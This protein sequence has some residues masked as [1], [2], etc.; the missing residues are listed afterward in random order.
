M[1][2]NRRFLLVKIDLH[3]FYPLFSIYQY[4]ISTPASSDF[5]NLTL[6]YLAVS[7]WLCVKTKLYS[8]CMHEIGTVSNNLFYFLSHQEDNKGLWFVSR[9]YICQSKD[10]N[11][12]ISCW[13]GN[14][15]MLTLCCWRKH[16]VILRV[17]IS[18]LLCVQ[19]GFQVIHQAFCF[20]LRLSLF[21]FF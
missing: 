16:L 14:V 4:V 21:V 3:I 18:A 11:I 20:S 19:P 1:G 2:R 10:K 7:R 8:S 17:A 12:K 15:A 13:K 6:I 5:K 9:K